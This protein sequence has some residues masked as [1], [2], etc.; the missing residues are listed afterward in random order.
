[1]ADNARKVHAGRALDAFASTKA[2]THIQR[3][4]RALPCSVTA[5]SGGIVTVKFEVS[6]GYTLPPVQMPIAGSIY[7]RAP[8]QVGDR[9]VA[10]PADAHLGISS[11]LGPVTPTL[12]QPANLAALH[13]HPLGDA[14]WP[15]PPDSNAFLVQGPNGVIL[16]DMGN[17]CTFA[18]SPSGI[19]IKAGGCTVAINAAGVTVT[20]GEVDA[21]GIGLKTHIHQGGSGDT[22][23]PIPGAGP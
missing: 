1:M 11:G 13:F 10:V 14:R 17:Q 23:P 2:L 3:T 18:L 15:A 22:G 9:G 5:V 12:D 6:S 4:G 20:N 8:T 7:A 21:D 19:V 16:R